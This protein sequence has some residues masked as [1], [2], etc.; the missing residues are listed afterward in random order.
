[1]KKD[2]EY[3]GTYQ[4][5]RF[6]H[7]LKPDYFKL[8]DRTRE[9]LLHEAAQLASHIKYYNDKNQLD[10]HWEEF[11]TDVYD[12]ANKKVKTQF[13][14]ELEKKGEVPPHLGLFLAFADVFHVAQ[15]EL[16]RLAQRHLDYYYRHILHFEPQGAVAD[17]VNLFFELAKK[18][19]RAVLPQGT[20]CDGGTDKNGRKR[21]YATDFNISVSH[22]GVDQVM[23]LT[24]MCEDGFLSLSTPHED[25]FQSHAQFGFAL[26]SPLLSLAD[27]ERM[28]ELT[29]SSSVEEW[30][31][32]VRVDYSSPIGWISL[33]SEIA[34]ECI[35]IHVTEKMPPIVIYDEAIHHMGLDAHEPVLRCVFSKLPSHFI[36]SHIDKEEAVRIEKIRVEVKN[37]HELDCFTDYGIVNRDTPFLPFGTLPVADA[38]TFK[39]KNPRIFNSYL[40]EP[41][42]LHINWKGMPEDLAAYYKSYQD[43]W[44]LLDHAQQGFY[45]RF[46]AIWL[47]GSESARDWLQL[48]SHCREYLDLSEGQIQFVSSVDYGQNLY[49]TL[50]GKVMMHNTRLVERNGVMVTNEQQLSIPEKPYIPEIQSIA[51]SYVLESEFHSSNS[52]LFA[53]HPVLPVEHPHAEY[54]DYN[55]SLWP[56]LH[57]LPENST[58]RSFNVSIKHLP[59]EGEFNVYFE[60]L[61]P[62][63]FV[64]TA[65]TYVWQYLSADGWTDFS[66]N[67]IIRDTTDHFNHSGVVTFVIPLNIDI[68]ESDTTWLRLQMSKPAGSPLPSLVLARTNCTTATFCDNDNDL[69]HL[70]LGLPAGT[71]SR[72][73]VRNA[74]IKSVEQPSSSFD[75]QE[76]ES[77]ESFYTRI[78]ERLRHKNRASSIWDYER[79]V[80]QKYPQVSFALCLPNVR[81][82]KEG[83]QQLVEEP[84]N[85]LLLLSPNAELDP[86]SNI[87]EP[88]VSVQNL[89]EIR[90]FIAR[91]TSPHVSIDV[92]NF[93]YRTITVECNV[94]LRKGYYDLRHYREQ[95]NQEL[96]Q[97]IAPWLNPENKDSVNSLTYKSKNVSDIYFFLENLEYVDYVKSARIIVTNSSGNDQKIYTI[98]DQ[99][100]E[101]EAYEMFTSAENHVIEF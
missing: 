57:P 71:V 15:E 47:N 39:I 89:D 91:H 93:A 96:R 83:A 64:S 61:N 13:L 5:K 16:N 10:G 99:V 42:S 90:Q 33:K 55:Y 59:S 54:T 70:R 85:V 97:Y 25:K 14:D 79:M 88:K 24:S 69:S 94:Q 95:L 43:G 52:R 72:L 74:A 62:S 32:L 92:T 65:D 68:D 50:L 20:L 44:G 41:Y 46:A 35:K 40:K 98:A 30:R 17:R 8:D 38:S 9:G 82:G 23:T 67:G 101:K 21:V 49:N 29:F 34:D 2:I 6:P 7:G 81:F 100:I 87:L 86:Q 51:I 60:I 77:E 18:E 26:S 78:S 73:V 1:M 3:Q 36:E 76:A 31:D 11:F 84:G 56:N 12:Y 63:S 37:S 66:E 28:I 80:L 27:G 45:K 19:E 53:I 58:E 22:A 75:G 48:K 4:H